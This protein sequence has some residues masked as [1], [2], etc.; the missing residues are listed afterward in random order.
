MVPRSH[1]VTDFITIYGLPSLRCKA[2]PLRAGVRCRP[3][4]PEHSRAPPTMGTD[5]CIGI[6]PPPLESTHLFTV[7]VYDTLGAL[8]AVSCPLAGALGRPPRHRSLP[9]T[10]V[11]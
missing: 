3:C 10:P 7:Q 2:T 1:E 9:V 6:N 8:P 11:P 5:A 4:P